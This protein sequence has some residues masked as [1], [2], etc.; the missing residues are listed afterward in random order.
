MGKLMRGFEK[1]KQDLIS[2]DNIKPSQTEK[3]LGVINIIVAV[4]NIYYKIQSRIL[5]FMFNPCN[6][7][8]FFLI[9]ICLTDYNLRG[10]LVAFSMYGFSFGGL[11]GIIF[12]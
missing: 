11:L 1:R 7:S 8:T 9:Y 10:E 5:V 6:I 2:R 4:I 12:N 3:I